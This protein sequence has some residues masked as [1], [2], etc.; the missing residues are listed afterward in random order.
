MVEATLLLIETAMK[1][2]ADRF[3]LVSGDSLPIVSKAKF[4]N[5]LDGAIDICHHR[6]I[7]KSENSTRDD[8]Y[9]RRYF[10][11]KEYDRLLPRAINAFSKFWP[12]PINITKYLAPL[13]LQIGS[14]FWSITR[15]T[16]IKI[17]EHHKRNP[18]FAKYFHKIKLS[19]E[20]FFQTLTV[21]YSND[22]NGTGIMFAN[23]DLPNAPHPS[24]L[25]SEILEDQF[26]SGKFFFA[27]KFSTDDSE[28]LSTWSK[29]YEGHLI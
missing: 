25:S 3:T 27:R 29:L 26:K 20:T 4:E 1:D 12:I 5:L 7:D 8:Q 18:K 9:Y 21:C 14:Q 15:S 13:D 24:A 6:P 19:D 11:L 22:L 10:S 17:L 28:L 2:G 23:W 16:M